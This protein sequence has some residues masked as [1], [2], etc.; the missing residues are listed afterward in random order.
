MMSKVLPRNAAT[1]RLGF[2]SLVS[3]LHAVLAQAPYRQLSVRLDIFDQ[4]HSNQHA[5]SSCSAGRM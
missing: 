3:A 2:D 1:R 5:C 4:Q